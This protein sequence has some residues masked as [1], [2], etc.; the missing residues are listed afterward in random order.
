MDP[1]R[2]MNGRTEPPD[3][4]RLT[5]RPKNCAVRPWRRVKDPSR[6]HSRRKAQELF[7]CG[8]HRQSLTDGMSSP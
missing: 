5:R 3:F 6:E 8:G 4:A 7:R 2:H 1:T